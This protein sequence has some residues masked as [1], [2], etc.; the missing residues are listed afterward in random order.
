MHIPLPP[1]ENLLNELREE[2]VPQLALFV[3]QFWVFQFEDTPFKDA[4]Q[5]VSQ[6]GD[7]LKVRLFNLKQVNQLVLH[8]NAVLLPLHFYRD[9][10]VRIGGIQ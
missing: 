6:F 8:R 10:R 9:W 3:A 2:E 1:L 7:V 5:L 4:E